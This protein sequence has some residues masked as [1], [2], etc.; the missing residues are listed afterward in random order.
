MRVRNPQSHPIF[1]PQRA[2]V[3][4][5]VL[6]IPHFGTVSPRAL[7]LSFIKRRT[8]TFDFHAFPRAWVCHQLVEM[9]PQAASRPPA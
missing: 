5:S 9:F 4:L 1:P 2:W 7:G 3:C 8:P 6:R